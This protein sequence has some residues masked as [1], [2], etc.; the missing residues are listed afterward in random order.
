MGPSC[1]EAG[2][3]G[4]MPGIIGTLQAAEALKWILGVGE[5]LIGRLLLVE[6]LGMSFTQLKVARDPECPVCREGAQIALADLD[7]SC[8]VPGAARAGA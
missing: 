7:A 8:A 6:A 3:L 4:V 1:A 5:P 2:V